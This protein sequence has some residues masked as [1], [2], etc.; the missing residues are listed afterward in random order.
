M[1]FLDC[2]VLLAAVLGVVVLVMNKIRKANHDG[3][4]AGLNDMKGYETI[5]FEAPSE[6][7]VTGLRVFNNL[8]E[9]MDYLDQ[10]RRT[11]H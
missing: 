1:D 5:E 10:Q 2:L 9:V 3:Y 11:I 6:P 4:I 8:Q 7:P